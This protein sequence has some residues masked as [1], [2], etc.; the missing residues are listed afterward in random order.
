MHIYQAEGDEPVVMAVSTESRLWSLVCDLS[1]VFAKVETTCWGSCLVFWSMSHLGLRELPRIVDA[2]WYLDHLLPWDTRV[3]CWRLWVCTPWSILQTQPESLFVD[4][5][6]QAFLGCV[7][8]YVIGHWSAVRSRTCS[9]SN[10][11][12]SSTTSTAAF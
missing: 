3:V 7:Q 6:H 12:T 8:Y 5:H 2:S 9:T 4:Q 10:Q 11:H 1:C